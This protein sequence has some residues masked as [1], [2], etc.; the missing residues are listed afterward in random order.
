[1]SERKCRQEDPAVNGQSLAAADPQKILVFQ[2][3][4]SGESKIVG[5][6]KQGNDLFRLETVSIDAPL[7]PVI[8]DATE[9]LPGDIEADLVLDFLRHP[10]LSYDLATMCRLRHIPVVASGKK[11]RIEGTVTPPT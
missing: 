5:I 8:D 11:M 3:N 7:P 10:D 1:M 4:G 9:Y 2:Q 6:R